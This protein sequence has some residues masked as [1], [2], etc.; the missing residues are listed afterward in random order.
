MVLGN[1]PIPWITTALGAV[2][3]P[4][5][6][7]VFA[8]DPFRTEIELEA[9]VLFADGTEEIWQSPRAAPAFAALTYHWELWS[10]A[11]VTGY[12]PLAEA[13]AR[14]I[15]ERYGVRHPVRVT[16]R[17]R[18]YDVVPPGSNRPPLWRESDFYVYTVPS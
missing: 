10:R 6:W 13:T 17:R 3:L 8:P 18:W 4:Q 15:V 2:G 16:L 14:W 11:V 12:P 1:L 7:D 5:A 9:T